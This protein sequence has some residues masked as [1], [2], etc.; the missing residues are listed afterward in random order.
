MGGNQL[1]VIVV[2]CVHMGMDVEIFAMTDC[3]LH[4][5]TNKKVTLGVEGGGDCYFS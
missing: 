5:T 3:S 1:I 2:T 4:L